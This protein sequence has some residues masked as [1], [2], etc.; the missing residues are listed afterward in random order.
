VPGTSRKVFCVGFSKTSTTTL[1]R[2]LGDQLS[3]RSAHKPGWTDW[4]I[5]KNRHQLDRF[6]AF[7]DGECAAIRNLD[8]LYPEAL[9]VLNTRPLKHWVLSRHKAVERSRT[10][11]RWALTKYVPLG[12]VAR[13]INRW[14][15]DN[16]ERAVMRWIRIRNSYHEHVIRY[17]SD[18]SGKLLVMNIEEADFGVQLARFLGAD[19]GAISPTLANRDGGDTMTGTILDAIGERVGKQTSDQ[20]IE[21]FFSSHGL[22]G[23]GDTLTFFESPR[24]GLS[25]S[26]SDYCLIV[27]PFLRPLFRWIY[28][29][30]VAVRSNARSVLSNWLVDWLIRFFRSESD[31]HYF[32][33]VRQLGGGFK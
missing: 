12:F 19:E 21:A 6:E 15:L 7:T 24:S 5:T 31:M 4:S 23:H 32:T 8:D 27:L 30:L 29:G 22:D 17:F 20:D 1:H 28:T 16:R 25:R 14:V 33:T 13:I 11:V 26:A 9:F 10:G 2:I 3:Y 18:R